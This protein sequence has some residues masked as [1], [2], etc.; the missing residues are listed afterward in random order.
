MKIFLAKLLLAMAVTLLTV[1]GIWIIQRPDNPTYNEY[2]LRRNWDAV[3][4]RIDQCLSIGGAWVW[5]FESQVVLGTCITEE[6]LQ[7]QQ[8]TKPKKSDKDI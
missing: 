1:A 8:M 3:R 7:K 4:P 6:D 5:Q 2:A